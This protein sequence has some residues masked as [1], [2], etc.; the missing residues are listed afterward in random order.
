MTHAFPAPPRGVD[1]PRYRKSRNPTLRSIL[2]S[3]FDTDEDADTVI[4]SPGWIRVAPPEE[5]ARLRFLCNLHDRA[6]AI[7]ATLPAD[8]ADHPSR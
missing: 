6:E 2:A 7:R 8:H 4:P 5:A 1:P 3:I